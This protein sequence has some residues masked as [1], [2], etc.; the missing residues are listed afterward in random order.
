MVEIIRISNTH[1]MIV[2]EGKQKENWAKD[3]GF[4]LLMNGRI[5]QDRQMVVV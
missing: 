2:V 5:P 3:V 1:V 4:L